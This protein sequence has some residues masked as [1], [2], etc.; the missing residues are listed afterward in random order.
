MRFDTLLIANRGEIACRI[1][2]TARA[3]GL[4][5]VAIY[6]DADADAPHVRAADRAERIGAAPVGESYLNAEAVLEA[7]RRS[8]AGAIHP[9]Y[10]FLSENADFARQ[11]AEAGLIFV[12][13]PPEAIETMGDK[14]R[15]KAA[16]VAHDVPVI[17]GYDG[18]DQAPETLAAEAAR[19]GFPV[20]IKAAAGGGG[21]GMRRVATS[22]AFPEALARAQSEAER[23][24]GSG[25]VLLEQALDDVRHV[26]VQ[27]MA[28][29][30]GTC[31]HLGERDC[32][33]QRRHQKVIEEAPSPGVDPELR[34]AMGAAAVR[35][36]EAVDYRGAGT[37]EFLLTGDGRYVFLEMNTRLQVEHP[38]TEQVTGLDLVALQLRVAQ[39]LPLG[40]S[41]EDVR[42]EGHAIELRLYAEDPAQDFL[43]ATG[44]IALWRPATGAGMRCDDGIATGGEVTPHYDPMLAKLIATGATRAEALRLARRM[45]RET[46]LIG[47]TTNAAFLEEVLALPEFVEGRATTGLLGAAFPEG[48]AEAAPPTA[49][50]ALTAA[51]VLEDEAETA[52]RTAGLGAEFTMLGAQAHPLDVTIGGEVLHLSAEALGSGCWRIEGDSWSHEVRTGAAPEVDGARLN[53]SLAEM[54]GGLGASTGTVGVILARHR[55]WDAGAEGASADALLAPMPGQ[56]VSVSC[57]PGDSVSKGQTLAVVEAMKM[58]HPLTAPRDGIVAEVRAEAGAQVTGGA[59]LIALEALA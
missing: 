34:A 57:A 7:A 45:L 56:V 55:P 44:Q 27:I 40:L 20:M 47:V 6:S 23:A 12:G 38:V 51:T 35:A 2:R 13:P 9:G 46:H 42:L 1:I 26:E 41:Q 10:G 28:D 54:A 43:P 8:G 21:R 32:S 17:A 33:V 3:L 52:R 50:V 53:A 24:F 30:H 19:I 58:Q 14:A 39:G 18:A 48:V 37:V 16:V 49:L 59:L 31:L 22:E 15:A 11:V 25:A 36:A 29:G 5:T 4:T